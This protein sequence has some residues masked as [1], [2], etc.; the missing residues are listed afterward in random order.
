V[1]GTISSAEGDVEIVVERVARGKAGA[2]WLFSKETLDRIP[3]LFRELD[4]IPV[5]TILPQVLVD[6]RVAG[7]ALF[8]WLGVFVGMPAVYFLAVLLNRILGLVVG[9]VRRRIRKRADLP[10]PEI[11]PV[12]VRLLLIAIVIGGVLS[13][14]ALPSWPVNSGRPWQVS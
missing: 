3:G 10:D 4:A 13:A 2:L 12:P 6:T 9:S 11:I 8:E 7:I 5:N 1:V 14:V